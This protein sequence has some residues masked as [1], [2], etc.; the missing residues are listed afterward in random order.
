MARSI[1][2]LPSCCTRLV[3]QLVLHKSY[4]QGDKTSSWNY[5]SCV[6][7]VFRQAVVW[8][9]AT[10]TPCINEW[11]T[12]PY[13]KL[14]IWALHSL[15][16]GDHM[17]TLTCGLQMQTM[18]AWSAL[19]TKQTASVVLVCPLL[20]IPHQAWSEQDSGDVLGH[21]IITYS[22]ASLAEAHSTDNIGIFKSVSWH[23]A[24]S[25]IYCCTRTSAAASR[26]VQSYVRFM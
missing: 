17:H 8:T 14:D 16:E 4:S 21:M 3:L 5:F 7:W 2:D 23:L 25:P 15:P 6:L 20:L 24:Q 13:C 11:V 10:A 1:A 18:A 9:T 12:Y 22:Y 19:L 26:T